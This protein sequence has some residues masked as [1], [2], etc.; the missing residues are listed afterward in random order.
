MLKRIAFTVIAA[1]FSTT[2]Y[3]ACDLPQVKPS[4]AG[5]KVVN[6]DTGWVATSPDYPELTV[7][8]N[9]QTPSIPE[10]YEWTLPDRYDGKIGVLQYFAGDPGTSYLVN[11]VYNAV[12]DI[13]GRRDLGS[14]PFTED[15]EPT[16]W[17]WQDDKVEVTHSYGV[18]VLPFR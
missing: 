16:K 5:W 12:I 6:T 18:D 15:C 14:A 17:D 4:A 11:L 13:P 9:M 8:L 10:I 7:A 3:A 1:V 2:A